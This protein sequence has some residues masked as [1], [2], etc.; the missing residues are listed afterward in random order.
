MRSMFNPQQRKI[1]TMKVMRVFFLFFSI[2]IS[3]ASL[4][5]ETRLICEVRSMTKDQDNKVS[6]TNGKVIVEINDGGEGGISIGVKSALPGVSEFFLSA[7]KNS[8]RDGIFNNSD[9]KSW[10]LS[11]IQTSQGIMRSSSVV[12]D[13][14]AGTIFIK[15]GFVDTRALVSED[16][17]GEGQCEPIKDKL[18]F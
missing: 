14:S 15:K 9:A 16:S 3:T 11:S 8:A 5:R 17:N 12:I 4:S 6:R 2:F 13:R 1:L 18:K 10:D 7:N